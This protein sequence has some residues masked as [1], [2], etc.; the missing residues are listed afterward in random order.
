ME[1][2]TVRQKKTGRPVRFELTEQT[3]QAVDECLRLAKMQPGSLLFGDQRGR[4]S[5]S[6]RRLAM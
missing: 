6:A 1:R 2:A 5:S 4:E 3:R